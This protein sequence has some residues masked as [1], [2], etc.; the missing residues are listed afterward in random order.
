MKHAN[1]SV[2]IPHLA[3]H[4]RCVFC[5]Q[6]K[7]SGK[8]RAPT[9]A[10]AEG[11]IKRA[12]AG[13][14]DGLS[15]EIAFFGGSFTAIPPDLMEAYLA[16]A[17]PYVDGVKVTGIRLSTRPDAITPDILSTLKKYGVTDIEL[18]AQSMFDDVL[19]LSNRGHT[20]ADTVRASSL[21]K[22]AGFRLGLQFMPGLPGDDPEKSLETAKIIASLSPDAVRV[23]PTLVIK[24]TEL[25]DMYERGD[26]KPYD[27][28]TAVSLTAK[29]YKLFTEKGI[30]V[31]R[32]GLH[33]D[34]DPADVVAGPYHPAFGELV[35]SALYLEKM[36]SL[37]SVGKRNPVF[38]VPAPDLSAALGQK[39][40]NL[41]YLSEK[42]GALTRI[43]PDNEGEIPDDAI[44]VS[45]VR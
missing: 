38:A 43:I 24:N 26:Y 34:I 32:M 7:I 31:L 37:A 23:Y 4:H 20:A 44:R 39:K 1:V 15:A 40:K 17:S 11:I 28:D 21:I 19:S 36:E 29:M 3:C 10:E 41:I 5:D 2:F 33:S 18:G 8:K 30:A 12:V 25:C 27:L 45:G 42:F 6:I 22:E 13:L 14:K 16:A 35:F 9:P